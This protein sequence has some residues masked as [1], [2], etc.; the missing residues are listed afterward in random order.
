MLCHDLKLL[1]VKLPQQAEEDQINVT[2]FGEDYHL[3]EEISVI[4]ETLHSYK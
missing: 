4:I 2:H 3:L 1:P